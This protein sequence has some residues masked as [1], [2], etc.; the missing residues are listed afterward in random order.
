MPDFI[1]L[2]IARHC[3]NPGLRSAVMVDA[4]PLIL[5]QV[6]LLAEEDCASSTGL[7]RSSR[8]LANA[9]CNRL[10]EGGIDVGIGD[11]ARKVCGPLLGRL[12]GLHFLRHAF[13]FQQQREIIRDCA[14]QV[15]LT[16]LLRLLSASP[17]PSN[18][19]LI[20]RLG[21][22]QLSHVLHSTAVVAVCSGHND[23]SAQLSKVIRLGR[24][25]FL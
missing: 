20:L 22:G 15:F 25:L 24:E 14:E 2:E 8:R 5:F 17:S 6:I 13:S 23:G 1:D 16:R 7:M 18:E 3:P 12:V 9:A 4:M 21:E 19:H 11:L 10:A